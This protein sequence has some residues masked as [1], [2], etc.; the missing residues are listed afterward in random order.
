M[1]VSNNDLTNNQGGSTWMSSAQPGYDVFLN[2]HGTT[3]PKTTWTRFKITQHATALSGY[4]QIPVNFVGGVALGAGPYDLMLLPNYLYPWDL[5][6]FTFRCTLFPGNPNQLTIGNP[7]TINTS[8]FSMDVVGNN[9]DQTWVIVPGLI[10]PANIPGYGN[11]YTGS[12]QIG[13]DGQGNM[14]EGMMN[15]DVCFGVIAGE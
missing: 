6:T 15:V 13:L 14:Q 5:M 8:G 10:V 9:L 12:V 11:V 7:I 2:P 1:W 4:V 3:S